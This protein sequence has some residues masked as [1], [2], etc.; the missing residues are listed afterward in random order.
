MVN[1]E[2]TLE[3][4]ILNLLYYIRDSISHDT[5]KFQGKS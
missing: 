2:I 3:G 4:K 5:L 1:K